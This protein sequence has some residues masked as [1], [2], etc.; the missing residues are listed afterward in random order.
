M[1]GIRVGTAPLAVKEALTRLASEPE[2]PRGEHAVLSSRGA[3][4]AAEVVTSR[5]KIVE[6]YILSVDALKVQ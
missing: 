2:M 5:E 6:K 3:A 1:S 4:K